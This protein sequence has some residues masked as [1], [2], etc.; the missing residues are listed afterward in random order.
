MIRSSL[1]RR[2]LV[3]LSLVSSV[4]AVAATKTTTKPDFAYPQTVAKNSQKAFDLA[5][6]SGNDVQA[7]RA[8]IDYALAQTNI[9]SENTP[10]AIEFVKSARTKLTSPESK[11]LLDILLADIYNMVFDADSYK[12]NSRKFPLLP[13]PN[14]ITEWSGDQF[15]HEITRL[16][17]QALGE[18]NALKKLNLADYASIIECDKAS[19]VYFPTLYDF[20]AHKSIDMLSVCGNTFSTVGIIALAPRNV[21]IINPPIAPGSEASQKILEIYAELLKFHQDNPA[22]EIYCDINRI[23]F[24]D[25]NLYTSIAL[26]SSDVATKLLQEL[27]KEYSSTEYCGDILITLNDFLGRDDNNPEKDYYSQLKDFKSR[28]PNFARIGCISNI[29]TD[30]SQKSIKIDFPDMVAPEKQFE[31]TVT[32]RN[33]PNA[34][35]KVFKLNG[36]STL[37]TSVTGSKLLNLKPIQEIPVDFNGEI[38]YV[39]NKTLQLTFPSFGQYLVAITAPEVPIRTDNGYTTIECTRLSAGKITDP[40]VDSNNMQAFVI[41]PLTGAPVGNASILFKKHKG[42]FKEIGKTAADGFFCFDLGQNEAGL[43][44]PVMGNDKFAKEI[45]TYYYLGRNSSEW[46]CRANIFTD[47]AI[48]HPG[49]SVR[50]CAAVYETK[51]FERR[52]KTETEFDAILFNANYKTIDTINV[53]SDSWGRINGAF[54]LPKGELT[55]NYHIGINLA[56]KSNVGSEYF[57]VSDYKMPTYAITLDPAA[58]GVP[59]AGDVTISGTVKTYSGV[60]LGGIPV[61]A[62][63]SASPNLW[64]YR[65]YQNF[66]TLADTTDASGKFSVVLTKEMI[67]NSPAPNGLFMANVSSTSLSGESQEASC[68]FTVGNRYTLVSNCPSVIEVSKPIDLQKYVKVEDSENQKVQ[69]IINYTISAKT[70]NKTIASGT[71]D[72]YVNWKD[73]KG[74]TY[75]LKLS[76]P[77]LKTDT[78]TVDNLVIYRAN[79]T[80]SP[81]TET[82]WSPE[83]NLTI[84]KGNET[85][86]LIFAA[87]D[88]THALIFTTAKGKIIERRWEKLRKGHNRV[89]FSVPADINEASV[90]VGAT[91]NYKSANCDFTIKRASAPSLTL[92]IESFRDHL[93]SGSEE[94]WTI[95]TTNQDSTGV[96]A[97]LFGDLYNKALDALTN[98]NWDLSFNSWGP[99]TSISFP[100]GSRRWENSGYSSFM[101]NKCPDIT[102]PNFD[103]YGLS[104]S[105]VSRRMM[106]K[107]TGAV[108][109]SRSNAMVLKEDAAESESLSLDEVAVV[110][111][112]TAPR[113]AEHKS[114]VS[115]GGAIEEEAAADAGSQPEAKEFKYRD[116]ETALAFFHPT[117]NTDANGNLRFSFKLPNQN[118]T[119]ALNMV[120]YD[121]NLS[122]ASLRKEITASKPIMVQP[123]LPRFLRSGDKAIISATVMNN[124][125]TATTA[126]VEIEIF[127]P[128]DMKAI[129]NHTAELALEPNASKPVEIELSA[130]LDA[131]FIGYR[132]KASN[133]VFADGEQSVIPILP[134][135]SPVIESKPFYLDPDSTEFSMTI[136]DYPADSR[137]T[138][139]YCDNPTWYVATAISGL[140]AKESRTA[141]QAAAAIFSASVADGI[142]KS[143]PQVESA[144]KSWSLSNRSDSVL[145]SMLQRNSD[146]KT[147]LLQATPWMQNAQSDTERMERL[148][149]LFDRSNISA[150]ITKNIALLKQLQCTD[151]GWA[152]MSSYKKSSEWA[153]Y[154]TLY[155]LG[156]INRLGFLPGDKK[157]KAMVEDALA[158]QQKLTEK[159]FKK[160]PKSDYSSFAVLRDL[161]PSVKPSAT[162]ARII[163]ATVQKQI[164]GWKKM[165]V[166]GKATAA[167]LLANHS[168]K[169]IAT[170]ILASLTQYAKTT[171]TQGMYWPILSDFAG[172]SM[173]ELTITANILEAYHAISPG[174]AA[175]DRIRQWLILQKETRDWGDDMSATEVAAAV[176]LTSPK[177]IEPAQKA[178]VMIG[179]QP[180][181]VDKTEATL[182]EFTT[183]IS[184]LAPS[185]KTLTINRTGTTP[186]WGAVT[187]QFIS[188]MTEVKAASCD[189][190]SIEKRFYRQIGDNWVEANEI[191]VGDRIKIE[192]LLH[193]NSAM[194]YVAISDE[195][196]ACLEPVEQLPAPIFSEG[197]CFYREN[198]D[199]STNIF[200]S[201]LPRGTYLLSYEMWVNNAGTFASGIATLQSQYAPVMTAHSSGRLLSS[202]PN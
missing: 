65:N 14:D 202:S 201:S 96:S 80:Y 54:Q 160:Y 139:R 101:G 41:D 165:T 9:G 143:L 38:P 72:S 86:A 151:G 21:F 47:L 88:D 68:N 112:G 133:A 184:S 77:E 2:L 154:R 26:E 106:Y 130:P 144:L 153:T 158:Y 33:V 168:Y 115:D 39:A 45:S 34:T 200:I 15:R 172:G 82:I 121:K 97:V 132:I 191:K 93:I 128:S 174:D 129:G 5:L 104:F 8:V 122:T 175:V 150:A 62:I 155:I 13:L 29:I 157:L 113:A 182:G 73:L 63:I 64:W 71:V 89:K 7:I 53:K 117:L 194:D 123:N 142:L 149:L 145:V 28:Y 109:G 171:P 40:T 141:P 75:T 70:N 198:R 116:N 167:M 148:A 37:N 87:E 20:V 78:F 170:Q 79:D 152:W 146:L 108:Y 119:W 52:L 199:A 23:R 92:R 67:A 58:S 105:P 186:A 32:S 103:T 147:F 136:T 135:F 164:A 51:N 140:S 169:R 76:T 59:S 190:V 138:L 83:I 179:T 131:A 4:I 181:R 35:I 48:Y 84:T 185:G 178:T 195:R 27:Y 50:W 69:T 49:D 61:K 19:R 127:T 98:H 192:L 95:R 188:P 118:T 94:T 57:K 102:E 90:K 196:A 189:A 6:K 36:S 18:A 110:G 11:A 197:L 25:D 183:N 17:S 10:Q 46:V 43:F 60:N 100:M 66:C 81:V 42:S 44:Q 31:V 56:G 125:D 107:L 12:Y 111:Y 173:T 99:Q 85:S 16:C 74:G 166:P 163:N 55:G 22:P 114:T 91:K 24:A 161:W 177:W 30:L 124:T 126:T 193:V 176:L 162:G 137:I 134:A 1:F 3:I 159:D 156:K 187:S 180:V 120:G